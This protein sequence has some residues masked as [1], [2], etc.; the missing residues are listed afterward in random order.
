MRCHS[1]HK[2]YTPMTQE[3][4]ATNEAEVSKNEDYTEEVSKDNDQGNEDTKEDKE[5][6][7]KKSKTIKKKSKMM[8]SLH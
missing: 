6:L 2:G 3:D 1:R 5:K 8:R 4:W 7:R